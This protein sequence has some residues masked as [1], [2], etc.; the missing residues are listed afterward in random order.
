MEAILVS[1]TKELE[2]EAQS[3]LGVLGHHLRGSEHDPPAKRP[4]PPAV[5]TIVGM[6]GLVRY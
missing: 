3:E 6:L 1:R 4:F 5:G 2:L